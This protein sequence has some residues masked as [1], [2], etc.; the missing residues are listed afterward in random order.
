[1]TKH[2]K[3]QGFALLELVAVVVIIGLVALVGVKVYGAHKDKALSN[4]TTATTTASQTQV[5]SDQATVPQIKSATDLDKASQ[6]LDQN[7]PDS[8]NASDS[9]Q[10]DKDISSF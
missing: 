5:S 8:S 4:E 6:M 2:A 9:A 3:Q 1:M 7:D 10:L